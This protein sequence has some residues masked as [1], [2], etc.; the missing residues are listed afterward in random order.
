VFYI[1]HL[2]TKDTTEFNGIESFVATKLVDDD[3]S[4]F[5]FNKSIALE[6]DKYKIAEKK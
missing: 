2:N 6:I 5:P 3:I 4:W 1:I